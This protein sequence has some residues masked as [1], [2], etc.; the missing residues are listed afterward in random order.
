M[1]M[2]DDLSVNVHTATLENVAVLGS[3]G[4]TIEYVDLTYVDNVELSPSNSIHVEKGL[5]T[6]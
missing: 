3:D 6:T 1:G 4:V 5:V 2:T